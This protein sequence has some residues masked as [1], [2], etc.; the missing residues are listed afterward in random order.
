MLKRQ[1]VRGVD[2]IG[3]LAVIAIHAPQEPQLSSRILQHYF[4]QHCG[5]ED[6]SIESKTQ[7][8]HFLEA[9]PSE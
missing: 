9:N 8:N 6:D 5:N 1:V 4:T 2:E 7:G 3:W